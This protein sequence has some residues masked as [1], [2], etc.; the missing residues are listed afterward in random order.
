MNKLCEEGRISLRLAKELFEA[1]DR[2]RAVRPGKISRNTWIAEAVIE[3][4]EREKNSQ[5][6]SE[7]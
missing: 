2:L 1:I 3:K 7:E 4:L 5:I 6:G